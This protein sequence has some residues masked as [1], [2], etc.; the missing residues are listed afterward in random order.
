MNED[1][2]VLVP[3]AQAC[4]EA[5]GSLSLLPVNL[6]W[7]KAEWSL[8]ARE[9][10][11]GRRREAMWRALHGAGRHVPART[12]LSGCSRY[13]GGEKQDWRSVM[14]ILELHQQEEQRE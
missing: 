4:Q 13:A 7:W 1:E 2:E 8:T 3:S 6:I 14:V 12:T 11:R 10:P 9:A 5:A